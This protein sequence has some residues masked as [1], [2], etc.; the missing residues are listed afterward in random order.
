MSAIELVL[1]RK[2]PKE[3][4]LVSFGFISNPFGV[5]YFRDLLAAIIFDAPFGGWLLSGGRYFR[6]GLEFHQRDLNKAKSR[7]VI[8]DLPFW[9]MLKLH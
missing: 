3:T 4:T 2:L 9:K 6:D 7:Y 5:R 8:K 1:Y